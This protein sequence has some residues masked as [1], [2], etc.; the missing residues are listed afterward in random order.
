ML[1]YQFNKNIKNNICTLKNDLQLRCIS[2]I[3]VIISSPV[4]SDR[5]K[6]NI[7]DKET[8]KQNPSS[9]LWE[10]Y[11]TVSINIWRYLEVSSLFP[12]LPYGPVFIP[13]P[14]PTHHTAPQNHKKNVGNK[15][16][17]YYT[18]NRIIFLTLKMSD[19]ARFNMLLI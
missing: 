15:R 16:S 4:L 18:R 5:L 14:K 7:S 13:P 10:F 12:A 17:L 3:L 11:L 9:Y 8:S 6:T 2:W 19:S 1:C